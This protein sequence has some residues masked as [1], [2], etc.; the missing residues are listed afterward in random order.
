MTSTAPSVPVEG[1]VAVIVVG[2]LTV[3]V[4]AG[5]PDPKL[6]AVA[7]EKFVPVIVTDVPLPA[8]RSG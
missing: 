6:T 2:L 1:A 5:V 7:P 8:P 3:N 4:V